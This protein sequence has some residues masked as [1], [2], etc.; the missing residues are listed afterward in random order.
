MFNWSSKKT[1]KII[2]SIIIIFI[3]LAMLLP[4]LTYFM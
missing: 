1:R 3:V 2:S 4:T